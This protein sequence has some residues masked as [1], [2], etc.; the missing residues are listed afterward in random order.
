MNVDVICG[1]IV[2][3]KSNRKCKVKVINYTSALLIENRLKTYKRFN[4]KFQI[5]KQLE[6]PKRRYYSS[7]EN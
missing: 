5:Y 1:N 2:S 3:E 7:L 6:M 4:F